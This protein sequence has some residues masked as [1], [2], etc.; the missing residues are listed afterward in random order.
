MLDIS[1]IFPLVYRLIYNVLKFRYL[2]IMNVLPLNQEM[3]NKYSFLN[4]TIKQTFVVKMS[5][6]KSSLY[7]HNVT[8]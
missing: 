3:F 6:Y 2:L 5:R 8:S 4:K 7:R 1:Q